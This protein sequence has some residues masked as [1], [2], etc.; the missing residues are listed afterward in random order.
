MT[1]IGWFSDDDDVFDR[2]TNIDIPSPRGC[3]SDDEMA[4]EYFRE[5][6][7][8]VRRVWIEIHQRIR[9][10]GC[11]SLIR[12]SQA[13]SVIGKDIYWHNLCFN[14]VVCGVRLVAAKGTGKVKVRVIYERLHCGSCYSTNGEFA[15]L[16]TRSFLRN[17]FIRN[18]EGP[19]FK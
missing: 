16:Y 8:D 12:E 6:L 19:K 2:R 9:C 7:Y 10:V 1:P 5:K 17:H 14:C 3:F 4:G 13:M 11:S 15:I 18:Q